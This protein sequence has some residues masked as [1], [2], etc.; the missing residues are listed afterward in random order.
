MWTA[1][2]GPDRELYP[3]AGRQALPGRGPRYDEAGYGDLESKFFKQETRV[4]GT[5]VVERMREALKKYGTPEDLLIIAEKLTVEMTNE[6]MR[7]ADLVVAA[8]SHY[9]G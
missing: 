3:G 8:F 4:K 7:Q 9:R 6:L 1:A 2:P 5:L